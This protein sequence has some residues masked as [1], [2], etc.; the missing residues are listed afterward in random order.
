MKTL[1]AVLSLLL[2]CPALAAQSVDVIERRI[3]HPDLARR[4]SI[5]AASPFAR[6]VARSLARDGADGLTHT[7]RPARP[8]AA[9][10]RPT[11]S[12]GSP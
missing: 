6:A 12:A 11:A 5:R 8:A 10:A 3:A 9:R 1:L 7:L 4:G 2:L